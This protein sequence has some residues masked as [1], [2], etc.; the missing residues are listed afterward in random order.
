ML[1]GLGCLVN[2][3]K[4]NGVILVIRGFWN[5]G[6]GISSRFFSVV[7]QNLIEVAALLTL[8]VTAIR[9]VLSEIAPSKKTDI[10]ASA[11]GKPSVLDD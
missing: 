11:G 3:Q 4:G 5:K 8:R 2:T 1:R 6:G 7:H 10:V 9:I